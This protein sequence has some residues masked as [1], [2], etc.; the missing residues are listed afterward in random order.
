[1]GDHL[2]GSFGGAPPPDEHGRYGGGGVELDA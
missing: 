2:D 1:M